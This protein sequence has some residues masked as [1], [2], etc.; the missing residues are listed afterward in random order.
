MNRLIAAALYAFT[1]TDLHGEQCHSAD[2]H[3]AVDGVE[4]GDLFGTVDLKH[5][6][7][8]DDGQEQS[9]QHQ[10]CVG[11]L[12]WPL[13]AT[14]GEG[15]TVK[16]RPWKEGLTNHIHSPY[17]NWVVLFVYSFSKSQ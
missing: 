6:T 12:P 8:A 11:Q 1:V 16:H 17:Y 13:V 15:N 14:P 2:A 9:Q 5:G 3:P 7:Q 10:P 4:G